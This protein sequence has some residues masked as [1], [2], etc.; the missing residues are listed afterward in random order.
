VHSDDQVALFIAVLSAHRGLKL[1]ISVAD[2]A[3]RLQVSTRQAQKIKEMAVEKGVLVGSSCG[4]S[5]GWYAPTTEAEI[6]AT[7]AQYEARI[8]SLAKLV[9]HTRGAAG[10]TKF[11]GELALEFQ[12]Q[13]VSV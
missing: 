11:V 9:R 4:K 12:E 3:G 8:R 6:N 5:H 10:Y 1:A 2:M 7:C 13:E